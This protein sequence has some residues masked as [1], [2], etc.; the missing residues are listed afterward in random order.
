LNEALDK[1]GCLMTLFSDSFML[2][3]V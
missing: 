1:L 2:L 3:V